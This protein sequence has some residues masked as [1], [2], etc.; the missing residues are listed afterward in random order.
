MNNEPVAWMIQYKDRHKFVFE[1]PTYSEH[2]LACEPLY[3]HPVKEL[4]DE[5][6]DEIS[7]EVWERPWLEVHR[8]FAKA[9]LRKAQ[10]K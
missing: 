10:E 6:I 4:T 8:K 5:E 1:K 3:T 9:I 2:I 7:K